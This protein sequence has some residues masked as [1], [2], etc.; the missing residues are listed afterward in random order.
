MRSLCEITDDAAK[1]EIEISEYYEAVIHPKLTA[2]KTT[3]EWR[4]VHNWATM[5]CRTAAGASRTMPLLLHYYF[6]RYGS[7]HNLLGP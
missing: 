5:E 6:L 1:L 2:C 3:E 7:E 4:S